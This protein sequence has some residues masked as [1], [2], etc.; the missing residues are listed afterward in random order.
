MVS[1]VNTDEV[2]GVSSGKNG[3]LGRRYMYGL[4]LTPYLGWSL[5]TLLGAGAGN[6]LPESV[7]SALGI[8]I[9]AMFVAIVTPEIKKNKKT[10]FCVLFAVV[11]SCIFT[12]LPLLSTIPGGFKVIICAGLASLVFAYFAPTRF[13]QRLQGF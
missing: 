1:F 11:L 9:Y 7:V 10:A 4:I 3:S 12:Y 13:F 8:A 2:F 5:G 6:I